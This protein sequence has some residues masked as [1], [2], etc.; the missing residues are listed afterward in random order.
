M[1]SRQLNLTWNQ[2]MNG[3]VSKQ[4][5]V[6]STAATAR[7]RNGTPMLGVPVAGHLK[8]FYKNRFDSKRV[9]ARL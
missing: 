8:G 2:L 7:Q 3:G 6:T 4:Y 9:R 5:P 1:P